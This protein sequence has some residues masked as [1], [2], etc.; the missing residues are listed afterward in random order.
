M[1]VLTTLL[2][3]LGVAHADPV[4]WQ[5]SRWV[6]AHDRI[7]TDRWSV[8]FDGLTLH[9]VP[10]GEIG[11]LGMVVFD[12]RG[13]GASGT[14]Q[15]DDA[16]TAFVRTETAGM[17]KLHWDSGCVFISPDSAG[18]TDIDG[19][20]EQDILQGVL[21]HWEASTDS[22]GYLTF[23]R[24][25]P[26]PMEVRLDHKNT[27]KYRENKWCI[28]AMNGAPEECHAASS[29]GLTTVFYVNTPGQP[30]DGAIRDADIEINA[31]NFA[32][33]VCSAPGV[34][35]TNGQGPVSDLANTLTHEVGHL[36]GL[37]HSC[38][39]GDGIQPT[40][41]TGAPAPRCDP[42]NSQT[43]V[44]ATMYP[45]QG[46]GEIKKATLEQDDI[47]GFCQAYPKADD[48]GTCERS[49]TGSGGCSVGGAEAGG[50]GLVLALV[51]LALAFG[52]RR[53]LRG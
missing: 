34:C 6:G 1:L 13:P 50:D 36:I 18:T 52:Q 32:V 51:G 43:I 12:L 53:R 35:V 37:D 5:A 49:S 2:A 48:P 31:V 17:A 4:F 3:T 44:D 28:P 42:S 10:G 38:W 15:A 45:S 26:A 7:V 16:D 39:S 22:C 19:D 41:G 47:D 21:D 23:E 25:A 11:D 8:G 30:G 29:A 24:D 33:G 40:D 9:T 20:Q 46:D 14:P 27:V